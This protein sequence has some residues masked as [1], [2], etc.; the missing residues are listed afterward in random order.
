MHPASSGGPAGYGPASSSSLAQEPPA[1]T[2]PRKNNTTSCQR[3]RE[4][5][6]GCDGKMNDPLGCSKCREAGVQCK[7]EEAR[8]GRL[9]VNKAEYK[10]RGAIIDTM[11]RQLAALQQRLREHGL[12]DHI[13]DIDELNDE[14][15]A[16]SNPDFL[17]SSRSNSDELVE[18]FQRMVIEDGRPVYY[19]LPSPFV[20]RPQA[21]SLTSPYRIPPIEGFQHSTSRTYEITPMHDLAGS[22]RP[23]AHLSNNNNNSGSSRHTAID[24]PQAANAGA[25]TAATDPSGCPAATTPQQEQHHLQQLAIP[26]EQQQ[27]LQDH[28][29]WDVFLARAPD[30]S[31]LITRAQH[32]AVLELFFKFFTAWTLRI[33]PHLFLR[34]LAIQTGAHGTNEPKPLTKHYSPTLHNFV[35]AVALAFSRD[36]ALRARDLRDRFVAR[37]KEDLDAEARKPSLSTVQSYAMLSSYWSSVG[38][39][40]LGFMYFGDAIRISQTLGLHVK[41]P[42]GLM[43]NDDRIERNWVFWSIFIHDKVWCLYVGRSQSLPHA[44]LELQLRDPPVDFRLDSEPWYW[45]T[46]DG[47]AINQQAWLSSTFAEVVKLSRLA[48]QIMSGVYD[49]HLAARLGWKIGVINRIWYDL[50]TWHEN[51][52]DFLKI[53]EP[54]KAMHPAHIWMLNLAYEWQ[55]LL[56]FRPFYEPRIQKLVL[57]SSSSASSSS[58]PMA[59]SNSQP[60][61]NGGSRT[62][63]TP[64]PYPSSSS[65]SQ[66]GTPNLARA[67]EL[68]QLCLLANDECP[69][70]ATRVLDMLKAYDKL[71][72]LR[73]SPVTS[74]Q[75]AYLAGKTCLQTVIAG[76][77]GASTV[78]NPGAGTNSSASASANAT[79][80]KK[81]V[82]AGLKAREKVRDSAR[83]LRLIGQTWVSGVVTADMLETELE[84]EIARQDGVVTGPPNPPNPPPLNSGSNPTPGA[85]LVAGIT[86]INPSS[87][88]SQIPLVG[89][90]RPLSSDAPGLSGAAKRKNPE[91]VQY[92]G[93]K[94]HMPRKSMDE[95]GRVVMPS[96]Y[97]GFIKDCPLPNQLSRSDSAAANFSAWYGDPYTSGSVAGGSHVVAPPVP[98]SSAGPSAGSSPFSPNRHSPPRQGGSQ[99]RRSPPRAHQPQQNLYHPQPQQ[100]QQQSLQQQLP[101]VGFD[102]SQQFFLSGYG[103]Q[104]AGMM[105]AHDPSGFPTSASASS[106]TSTATSPTF[107]LSSSPSNA[108]FMP[109]ITTHGSPS[110]VYPA[111][112][113]PGVNP[114]QAFPGPIGPMPGAARG[115]PPFVPGTSPP[116]DPITRLPVQPNMS[117][118]FASG[119]HLPDAPFLDTPLL[120]GGLGFEAFGM[121]MGMGAAGQGGMAIPNNNTNNWA[122]DPTLGMGFGLGGFVGGAGGGN[123]DTNMDR[124]PAPGAGGSDG[125]HSPAKN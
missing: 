2:K 71:F 104:P 23:C 13:P 78:G 68:R 63:P 101:T 1:P 96:E 62:R 87:V 75:I 5:K 121:G 56:L 51:L 111:Q 61:S 117:G 27:H 50:R 120:L 54:S 99:Q 19:S 49:Q 107:S 91:M 69:K 28:D 42:D 17:A 52:K 110:H 29:K 89:P 102:A 105:P 77:P 122:I 85:S 112:G 55:L 44:T 100:Q 60:G 118:W 37:G 90:A 108:S 14:E 106:S 98:G 22:E 76:A 57:S 6:C 4:K 40:T 119:N 41:I 9:T 25:T 39:Q 34:D 24:Q 32:D 124:E 93:A 109:T 86:M 73:L 88:L 26:S 72:G 47:R 30:G 21:E 12:P 84:G 74:V 58:A 38:E 79:A 114:Q 115:S 82:A 59:T 92:P 16:A 125:G 64:P 94:K 35:V 80:G 11:K 46:P 33:V 43:S 116:I 45:T 113:L 95:E 103:V 48:S 36:P 67:E 123:M 3:C 20:D 15:L 70:S 83:Y 31:R 53:P 10:Q 65:Q 7:W 18:G 81:A 97:N 8:D 66:S